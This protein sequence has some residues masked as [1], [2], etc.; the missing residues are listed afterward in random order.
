M[1]RR[2]ALALLGSQER[3]SYR[4]LLVLL[5]ATG[6]LA[7]TS[8]LDAETWLWV[9]LAYIG[10]DVLEKVAGIVRKGGGDGA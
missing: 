1:I 4:R 2:L 8:R 9:A 3:L 10:G 7:W 5:L 6:L